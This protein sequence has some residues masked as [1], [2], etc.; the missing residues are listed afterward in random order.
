MPELFLFQGWMDI[1]RTVL[2]G[3]LGYVALI[4]LLRISGKRTLSKMNAFDLVVTVALGSSL[5]TLLLSKDVALAEGIVAF[6]TLIGGQFIITWLSVRSARFRKFVKSEP[7]LLFHRGK[8]LSAALKTER[9]SR[10]EVLAAIRS[11]GIFDLDRVEA[12]VLE[13]DGSFTTVR[14]PP[15]GESAENSAL[16]AFMVSG[17]DGRKQAGRR[18]PG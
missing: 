18:P 6:A 9:V 5:A 3:I 2:V 11:Q 12:V 13:T 14:K 7:T 1:A 8:F 10:A 17:R 4:V 15:E 16:P